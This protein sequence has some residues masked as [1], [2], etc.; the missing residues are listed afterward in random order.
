M[1]RICAACLI[2]LPLF[3]HASEAG[4]QEP[5]LNAIA[6]FVL[7]VGIT[8][9]ITWWAARRTRSAHDFYTA[10]GGITG[11]QN[12]LAIA[13]DYMSA[14]TLLGISSMVFAKGYDGM[15][16]VTGFFVGWPVLTFL[17]AERLRNLGRY[18][19]ADIVSYRLDQRRIRILAACGSL[20]VVSCYLLL[21]MVGAGQ[22]IKLLFGLDYNVA[23]VVVGVLMLVY[24][25][26]GGMLATTWV[27]ITKAVLLLAG[28]TT[29]MLLALERFDFS[30][31]TLARRAVESHANGWSIMGPGSMLANPVNVA[32]M[33]IGLVFGLAGLPHIMMRFFTVPNAREA[34]KSVLYASGFIGFFFLVVCVL[35]YSSIVIVG[36]DPQYFVDGKLGGALLG[37]GNM[38][39]MH[40]AKAVG[41]NLF[42]GFISAVAFATI[43]AVV[44]GLTLAGASTIS[45]DL[46]GMVYKRGQASEAQEMRISRFAV[47]GLGVLAIALGMLFEQVNI[48]FLVGLTFGIAAS[49]NFPVLIMAM[50]WKRL[51]TRGAIW[52]GLSGLVAALVLVVLSPTVWVTVLGH[53]K[54]LFPYDH[55]ALFAMPL[56]FG[57]IVLVSKLDR[58]ARADRDR[59]GFEDQRVRAETGLGIATALSH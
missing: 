38:V 6:M 55:P 19:F 44:A 47:L 37:G 48:A 46:Y 9:L 58:S 26:F 10:G 45:H 39:A 5:N 57:M 28:G 27:Q 12:G 31:E 43:L 30:L 32:S 35:G 17:M 4:R 34:R 16:Y 8:L 14:S 15:I 36:T 49:A 22:L 56:A 20:T 24:V 40:L 53:A 13:G 52:G 11:L 3:A 51:T 21:Q 33:A 41:G 2:A 59:E 1:K 42:L 50:Y 29:L 18:T 54:A 23:V 25:V 7:F